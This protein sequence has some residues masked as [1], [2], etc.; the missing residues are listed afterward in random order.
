MREQLP[1]RDGPAARD[2]A[3]KVLLDRVAQLEAALL[4]ELEHDRSGERLRHAPDPEPVAG[5]VGPRAGR[6]L[7]LTSVVG[8]ED[9][10]AV[11]ARLGDLPCEALDGRR[12]RL[13][14]V[15]ATARKR[16]RERGDEHSRERAT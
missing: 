10:H 3:R 2:D 5:A 14:L 15:A 16:Y 7:E 4:D 1:D 12:C 13:R 6:R 9:D 11:P 8:D